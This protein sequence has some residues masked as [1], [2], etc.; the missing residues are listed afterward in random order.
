MKPGDELLMV[1]GKSLVGLTHA[2]A[3]DVLKSSQRLVQLVVATEDDG[4]SRSSSTQSIPELINGPRKSHASR[5][6][7]PELVSS[8]NRNAFEMALLKGEPSGPQV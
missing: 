6:V 5:E 3:V 4:D 7:A 1:D 2:E 8:P